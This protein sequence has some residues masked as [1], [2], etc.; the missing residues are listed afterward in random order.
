VSVCTVAEICGLFHCDLQ[1]DLGYARGPAGCLKCECADPCQVQ[2]SSTAILRISLCL[3][4]RD[5]RP[6]RNTV[7]VWKRLSSI[8]M[9][10]FTTVPP[11]SLL[12]RESGTLPF[13][14]ACYFIHLSAS[15]QTTTVL[16]SQR[17]LSGSSFTSTTSGYAYDYYCD[18][19]RDDVTFV[20]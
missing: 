18:L 12:L 1:C 11:Q 2:Y 10:A 4:T 3:T 9:S 17:E 6:S 8:H 16:L 19:L 7:T 5:K 15:F 14:A 13:P 20:T